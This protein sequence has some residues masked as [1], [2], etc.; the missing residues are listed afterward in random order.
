MKLKK[1]MIK[2]EKRKAAKL[3]QLKTEKLSDFLN[4]L[5]EMKK[6]INDRKM[7]E[8]ELS[9]Y[10]CEKKFKKLRK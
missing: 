7:I 5:N 10:L 2:K 6:K 8:N 3:V 4:E 9:S 1:R